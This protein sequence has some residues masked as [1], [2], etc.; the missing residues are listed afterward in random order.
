LSKDNKNLTN[1]LKTLN[2]N[3]DLLIKVTA[4]SVG[5]ETIFKG[6]KDLGDKILS[7][8]EFDLPDKII[9]MLVGSTPESV[10][11]LRSKMKRAKTGKSTKEIEF[12]AEDLRNVLNN[13]TL[14]P[15]TLELLDFARQILNV[16]PQP[17]N[18]ESKE[19]IIDHITE[20]FQN[21]DRIKQAL[22]IQALENRASARELKDTQFLK[23]L[24]RWESHIEG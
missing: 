2:E 13:A 10:R 7:L 14:F 16:S 21:S 12:H 6:M 8:D 15:S 9:A 22:F 5:K 24:E 17:A 19:K 18:Y 11:S 20:V 1:Q 4:I 3:I 23:F